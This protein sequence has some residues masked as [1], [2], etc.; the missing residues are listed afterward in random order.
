[1]WNSDEDGSSF[2][3]NNSAICGMKNHIEL[4]YWKFIIKCRN[5]E[6]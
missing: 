2:T 6:N 5:I 1:M 3:S 4:K